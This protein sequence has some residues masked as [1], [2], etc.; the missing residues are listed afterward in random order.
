M[1]GKRL[2]GDSADAG[3]G[4][5]DIAFPE[6]CE[7][8]IAGLATGLVATGKNPKSEATLRN[9]FLR[10]EV[11]GVNRHTAL[12]DV[13][14]SRDRWAGSRALWSPNNWDQIFVAFAGPC[15]L[16][17]SSVAGLLRPVSRSVDH[18][19]RVDLAP[20]ERGR[21]TS[22]CPLAPG[23]VLPI[24]VEHVEEMPC[25][26]PY[27]PRLPTGMIALDGEREVGF[28]RD[29]DVAVRLDDRGPSPLTRK[30]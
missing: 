5:D 11:N 4:R 20:L 12:V 10:V 21:V 14:V 18:G 16:G 27:R 28:C 26:T 24:G 22:S 15:A 13:S 23:L 9:K 6:H 1:G 7:A 17:L 25:G 30:R 2:R 29:E 3:P 19:L 8:T